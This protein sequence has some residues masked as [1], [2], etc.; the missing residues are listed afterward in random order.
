MQIHHLTATE[1]QIM[2][3]IWQKNPFYLKDLMEML[4]EPK[5]HQNTVSTYLK[6]LID[7]NFLSSHKE[8]R[9]CKYQVII[10]FTDYRLFLLKNFISKYCRDATEEI[11]DIVVE[12]NLISK[13]SMIKHVEI[14]A[15]KHHN[16]IRHTIAEDILK[17]EKKK[18][19]K[20]RKK[21]KQ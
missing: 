10:P 18:K 20:K 9:I 1:E 12:N 2:L 15:G 6:I 14:L 17:E 8:G 7:K 5:P 13:E 11:L 4:P 21:D 3:L 16:P 19:K